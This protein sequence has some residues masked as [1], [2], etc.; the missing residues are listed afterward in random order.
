MDH[1]EERLSKTDN[2]E[3]EGS[4]TPTAGRKSKGK[5]HSSEKPV[6]ATNILPASPS[7]GQCDSN[8]NFG[9]VRMEN[10]PIPTFGRKDEA[11]DLSDQQPVAAGSTIPVGS[12][13][14]ELLHMYICY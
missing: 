11:T 8:A 3:R 10:I 12:P 13:D 7:N 6:R 14:G 1:S 5:D 4:Q 9:I 2:S